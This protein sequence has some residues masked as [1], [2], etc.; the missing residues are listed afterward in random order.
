[1]LFLCA[2]PLFVYF[3]SVTLIQR[4]DIDPNLYSKSQ[5]N[6]QI[7]INLKDI[8]ENDLF[9]SYKKEVPYIQSTIQQRPIPQPPRP[10]TLRPPEPQKPV[11]LDPLNVTL[12]GIIVT[13][14]NESLNTAI[15]S[16]NKTDM[17]ALYKVGDKIQDSQLI[18]IFNNKIVL[19]RSN[20]QQEVL[21]M[22][23]QEAQS[24]PRFAQ[25][26]NWH[27]AIT[28]KNQAEYLIY[29]EAF[30]KRVE[31]LSHFIELLNLTTAYDKGIPI[32][33]HVGNIEPQTLGS[34]LGVRTGDMI[35]AINKKGVSTTN[36]RLS[37]YKQITQSELPLIVT[38]DLLR[39][40]RAMTLT[41]TIE[42][43]KIELIKSNNF[44][45]NEKIKSSQLPSVPT[46]QNEPADQATEMITPS[47]EE[48]FNEEGFIDQAALENDEIV[49]LNKIKERDAFLMIQ[50]NSVSDTTSGLKRDF[51]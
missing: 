29:P 45:S 40:K 49:F 13:S 6:H 51:V 3:S 26:Q 12:H 20:G 46:I 30:I 43:S 16:D 11:F 38:V 44:T 15:I 25:I 42:Q 1:L 19:L 23:E 10:Q 27:T 34:Y 22:R 21:Y 36:D 39:G 24:D 5:K 47:S 32:G 33:T 35:M 14:Q 37:V 28:M 17:E 50:N 48:S 8:Y 7:T 18:R 41:Y 31:N 9:D 4:E 2:N